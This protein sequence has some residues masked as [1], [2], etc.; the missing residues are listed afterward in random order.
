MHKHDE[1]VEVGL[2]YLLQ[3]LHWSNASVVWVLSN[4]SGSR[5]KHKAGE[6]KEGVNESVAILAQLYGRSCM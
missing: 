4:K 6:S 3:V 5:T 1:D 2:H